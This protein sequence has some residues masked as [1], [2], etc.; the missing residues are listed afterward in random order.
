M[1]TPTDDPAPAL[2]DVVPSDPAEPRTGAAVRS[3]RRTVAQALGLVWRALL[4]AAAVA[5]PI[6]GVLIAVGQ[7]PLS[8]ALVTGAFALGILAV[9]FGLLWLALDRPE[10]LS[11]P[12][13]QEPQT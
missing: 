5:M 9:P 8:D 1:S 11:D 7:K 2:A 13:L 12:Q 4:I 3:R 6:G 10:P